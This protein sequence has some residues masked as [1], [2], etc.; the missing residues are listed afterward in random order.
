MI[1][2]TR[3][4]APAFALLILTATLPGCSDDG[5]GK[6]YKVTGKITYKGEPVKHGLICF[7]TPDAGGRSATATI[8]DGYYTL[9][10]QEPG[11]GAFPGEYSVTVAAKTPDLEGAATKAK[12]KGNT[13][14]YTPPDFTAAAYKNAPNEVPAKYATVGSQNPLKAKVEPKSNEINFELTD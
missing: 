9:Q 7:I 2:G 11:D 4:A 1:P 14:A 3:L 12:A 8:S 6:R 10:T 13:A 5:L